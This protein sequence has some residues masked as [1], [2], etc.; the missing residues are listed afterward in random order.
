MKK[1]YYSLLLIFSFFACT[2]DQTE[3]ESITISS[4]NLVVTIDENPL[5]NQEIGQIEATTTSG[6]LNY[7]FYSQNIEN[8]MTI[9]QSTGVILVQNPSEFDYEIRQR[10]EGIVKVE[11]GTVFELVTVIVSINNLNEDDIEP[12]KIIIVSDFTTDISENPI[13]RICNP[14]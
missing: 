3:P 1:I 9:N 8:S 12:E 11:N 7:S 2:E 5:L 4:N 6:S 14:T 10:I 13:R